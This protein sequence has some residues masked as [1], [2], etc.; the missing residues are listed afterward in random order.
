MTDQ[1]YS[2][3]CK[4]CDKMFYPV[5]HDDRKEFEELCWVCLPLALGYKSEDSELEQVMLDLGLLDLQ[6]EGYGGD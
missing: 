3:R 4:A 6:G 2:A 5:W 1:L